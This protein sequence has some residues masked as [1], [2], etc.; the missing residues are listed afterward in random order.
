MDK[1]ILNLF[2]TDEKKSWRK[3]VI[4]IHKENKITSL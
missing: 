4:D 3:L 2:V 1:T